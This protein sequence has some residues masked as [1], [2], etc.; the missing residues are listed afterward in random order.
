MSGGV[1]VRDPLNS[2]GFPAGIVRAMRLMPNAQEQLV[3]RNSSPPD[4][5]GEFNPQSS[6]AR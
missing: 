2:L 5:L 4:F 6:G 3:P 1:W